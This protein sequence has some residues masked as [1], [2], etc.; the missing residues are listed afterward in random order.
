MSSTPDWQRA[1]NLH[2]AGHLAEAELLYRQ[3]LND[4]PNHA[5]ALHMLG[6]LAYQTGN[7]AAAQQLIS[8]ALELQ[9]NSAEAHCNL[10]YALA[11]LG[12]ADQ[13]TAAFLRATELNPQ[14]VQAHINLAELLSSDPTTLDQ[15]IHHLRRAIGLTP[16]NDDL[17]VRLGDLL[18]RA[19]RPREA[20]ET[21]QHL[22]TRHPSVSTLHVNL[23]TALYMTGDAR[24]ATAA[25]QRALEVD[26]NDAMARYHLALQLLAAGDYEA[27][28]REY[29][30]RWRWSDFPSQ[31]PH[32]DQP[33]W[34]GS[35]LGSGT[36][37]IHAEQGLGDMIQFARYAPLI[38]QRFGGNVMLEAPAPLLRLFQSL[39]N[40]T[41]VVEQGAPVP[42][43]DVHISLA[44]LPLLFQT[45]VDSIPHTVPYLQPNRDKI[46]TW[47]QRI[48]LPSTRKFRV[49]LA[50]SG[51]DTNP[52]RN[53]TLSELAPLTHDHITFFSLQIGR[54]SLQAATPPPGMHLIDLSANIADLTDTAA[55]IA[56]LDAVI[57][58]DTAVAHLA[59][60][61]AR[62]TFTLLPHVTDWRWMLDPTTTPWYPTMRLFRQ[63]RI[64][65]WSEP[66]AQL[67]RH[68]HNIF[69]PSLPLA[70]Y[71]GRG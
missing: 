3:I 71:A 65:D 42:P 28:W 33:R 63:A 60:A 19:S 9:P 6:V 23:G 36:L 14:L 5:G 39:P 53:V 68:L 40:V 2:T 47:R 59:G 16:E 32:F 41:A 69:L 70:R 25:Y 26:P 18:M 27:G 34:D 20:A 10:G 21:Y 50:W 8:R 46:D 30:W 38:Q 43:F 64:D 55:F 57:T 66:I 17:H 7:A 45:T 11:A 54:P 29:E 24:S 56:H 31:R 15:S 49:G 35:P 4:D 67:T 22:I 52:K 13:A 62:P 44:S 51:S 1:L 58:V 61:L 48:A 37:F 12:E